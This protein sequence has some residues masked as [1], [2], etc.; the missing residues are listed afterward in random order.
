MRHLISMIFS[1]IVLGLVVW[2]MQQVSALRREV[3]LLNAQV[4]ALQAA[5]SGKSAVSSSPIA[6]AQKHIDLAKK[7]ALKG[8]FKRA[9]AEL[10]KGL[11]M[12][13]TAGRDSTQ[14][15]VDG[16]N[17]LERALTETRGV[18]DKLWKNVDSSKGKGKGG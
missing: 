2:N 4:A 3:R 16:L 15:Y 6:K 9:D 5:K 1:L 14:P 17:K 11:S 7:Y 13:E 8:D 18:I 12:L 10:N